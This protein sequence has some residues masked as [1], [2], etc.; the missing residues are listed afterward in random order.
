[1]A[2]LLGQMENLLEQQRTQEKA[3]RQSI[4]NEDIATAQELALMAKPPKIRT[5][6]TLKGAPRKALLRALTPG[7]QAF[8]DGMIRG[9]T[10]RQ[11][12][13]DAYPDDHSNDQVISNAASDL[14][15]H[16]RVARALEQA[17]G[18]TI[19]YMLDDKGATQRWV[20]KQLML[21]VQTV[22]QENSRLRALQLVGMAVGMFQV[23]PEA[24]EKPLTADEL[25]RQ[26]SGHLTLVGDI[27][28]EV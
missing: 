1:M 16:P 14:C 4:F 2:D 13:R 11:A 9:K 3:A 21:S 15:K 24:Q 10:Q 7:Q 17:A 12:Y 26:L 18:E 28:P 19:D 5:D 20:M 23:Q 22:K 25:K 6:G 8:I 27:K